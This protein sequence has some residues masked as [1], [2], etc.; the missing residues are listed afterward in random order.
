MMTAKPRQG[1]RKSGAVNRDG[2]TALA[3]AALGFLAEDPERL[4]RFMALSGVGV[5]SIR[6]AARDPGFLLGVLDYLVG[7]ETLLVAFAHHQAI[8][9]TAVMAAHAALGGGYDQP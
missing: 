4:E 1:L 9:P 7:D 3:I 2:A 5:D 8:D 6:T